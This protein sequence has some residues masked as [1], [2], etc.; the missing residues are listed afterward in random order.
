MQLIKS[1]KSKIFCEDKKSALDDDYCAGRL[2]G[3]VYSMRELTST[4][5][6]QQTGKERE[7]QSIQFTGQFSYD[8]ADGETFHSGS[9][10]LPNG[11]EGV[12]LAQFPRDGGSLFVD[13]EVLAAYKG[14][15]NDRD[16]WEWKLRP[17]AMTATMRDGQIIA[18]PVA[19]QI[20]NPAGP[21]NALP[22]MFERPA[23][24]AVADDRPRG[25]A[26][27]IAASNASQAPLDDPKDAMIPFASE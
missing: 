9:L 2:R 5:K 23:P 1:L 21:E 19:F 16:N 7:S 25:R 13:I 8:R 27:K 11:F 12:I 26:A 24:L 3:H 22:R 15:K 10:F 14:V 6:D 4:F 20:D 18:L 17:V